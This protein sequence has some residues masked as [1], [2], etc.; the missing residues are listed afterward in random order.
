VSQRGAPNDF[1]ILKEDG[2]DLNSAQ[3]VIRC[4]RQLKV[5]HRV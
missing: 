3:H 2:K 4:I 1:F 5:W